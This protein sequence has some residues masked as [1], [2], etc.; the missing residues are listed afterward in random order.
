M[1]KDSQAFSSFSTNDL[2]KTKAFYSDILGLTVSEVEE[3]GMIRLHLG[4][5]GIVLI[6]PKGEHHEPASFTVLNFPVANVE[7][8]VDALTEKGVKFEHYTGELETNEKG[9]AGGDGRGPKIAWFK[10]P[11]GNILSVVEQ[12]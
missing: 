2:E 1:F 5:G 4:T 11:A 10:D 9:I 7:E 12:I 8:A 3:M 6:Y